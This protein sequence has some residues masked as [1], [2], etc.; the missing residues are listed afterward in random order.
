MPLRQT[1]GILAVVVLAGGLI[2]TAV[3]ASSHASSRS[4]PPAAVPPTTPTIPT[5]LGDPDRSGVIQPPATGTYRY[6][7]TGA[8]TAEWGMGIS[9]LPSPPGTIVKQIVTTTGVHQILQYTP[10][11][12]LELALSQTGTSVAGE[13][14]CTDQTARAILRLPLIPHAAWTTSTACTNLLGD[15]V[16]LV[17]V[18]RVVGAT[19]AHVGAVTVPV[20]EVVTVSSQRDQTT[21][22]TADISP[23]YGLVVRQVTQ[24]GSDTKTLRA[25]QLVSLQPA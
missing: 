3:R 6:R 19:T 25:D 2:T 24:D 8:S 4:R 18:T 20:W 7:P 12:V 10:T 17:R 16:T 9:T 14:R 22:V 15:H 5:T 13:V 11:A 1:I 21:T 23:R